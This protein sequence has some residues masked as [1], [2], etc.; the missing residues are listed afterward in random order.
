MIE[1]DEI[2][3]QSFESVPKGYDRDAVD[4][5]LENVAATVE[6]LHTEAESARRQAGITVELADH[7]ETLA[8]RLRDG[9]D[10]PREPLAD[11]DSATDAE[12][13]EE[14]DPAPER[15]GG[16][17]ARGD[18]A[19]PGDGT[20]DSE[21]ARLIALNLALSGEDREAVAA[22][23]ADQFGMTESGALLDEVYARVG[24]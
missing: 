19:P 9:D 10:A 22:H 17:V 3:N 7:L 18:A 21:A 4:A 16:E 1:A 6:E 14:P 12:A 8:G 13:P 11:V 15:D 24:R 23:L 20:P 2:R 5:Y